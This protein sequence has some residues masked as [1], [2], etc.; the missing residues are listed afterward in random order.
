[1]TGFVQGRELEELYSNAYLFVLPSDVEGMA[2]GLLEAMSYGNCCVV[3]DI[4]ENIEVVEDKAVSFQKGDS[5][6]LRD[7]LEFLLTHPEEVLKYKENSASFICNKYNWEDVVEK[8]VQVY[9]GGRQSGRK[10]KRM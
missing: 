9:G 6:D 1:M 8:T 5:D 7:K 2:L 4:P 10:E 3:S